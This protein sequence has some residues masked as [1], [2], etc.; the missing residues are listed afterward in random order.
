MAVSNS[1]AGVTSSSSRR[2]SASMTSARALASWE[3]G[4]KPAR[5]FTSATVRRRTG[6]SAVGALCIVEV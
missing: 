1:S 2:G 3:A 6:I 4:A 5:F